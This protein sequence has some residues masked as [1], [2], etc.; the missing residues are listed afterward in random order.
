MDADGNGGTATPSAF[1][2]A[3]MF[4]GK[5]RSGVHSTGSS[6]ASNSNSNSISN[7]NS[8]S[9]S[10]RSKREDRTTFLTPL[11]KPMKPKKT[12]SRLAKGTI[13]NNMLIKP[14]DTW[15]DI[16]VNNNRRGTA[17]GRSI[18]ASPS[19]WPPVEYEEGEN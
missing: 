2:E 11:K 3:L 1:M 5:I 18:E 8:N 19:L 9:N 6:R 16:R 10:R 12:L 14:L 17:H 4:D 13:S 7:S 15:N